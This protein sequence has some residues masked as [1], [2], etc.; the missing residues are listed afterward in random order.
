MKNNK[1]DIIFLL[2][3]KEVFISNQAEIQIF[4]LIKWIKKFDNKNI[5]VRFH[6]SDNEKR[7]NYIQNKFKN[8]KIIFH[9]PKKITLMQSVKNSVV[10]IGIRSSSLIEIS[11]LG[12]IPIILNDNEALL[13]NNFNDIKKIG[14]THDNIRDTKKILNKIFLNSNY[15]SKKISQ[16]SRIGNKYIKFTDERSKNIINEQLKYL[17]LTNE[18]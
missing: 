16:V 7:I 2:N 18:L 1:K 4:K 12:I 14:L 6:P 9:Y 3:A 11:K 13:E 15:C 10:A 5:I 17:K 8:T